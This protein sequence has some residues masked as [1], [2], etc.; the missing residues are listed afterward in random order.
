MTEGQL[1]SLWI[2]LG[3]LVDRGMRDIEKHEIFTGEGLKRTYH[4]HFPMPDGS[5][6]KLSLERNEPL[7]QS[8]ATMRKDVG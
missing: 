5:E 1:L 6:W 2:E 3:K 7:H 4:T 8:S